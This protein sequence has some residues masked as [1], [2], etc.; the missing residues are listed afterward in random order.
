[1]GAFTDTIIAVYLVYKLRTIN[2]LQFSY[3]TKWYVLI[4]HPITRTYPH[5][6]AVLS[7]KLSHILSHVVSLRRSLPQPP[8]SW[9][10]P[11]SD[12]SA[13]IL[14]FASTSHILCPYFASSPLFI[15]AF[16]LFFDCNGRVYTLTILLNFIT[17]HEWRK[18]YDEK[19]RSTRNDNGKDNSDFQWKG[20]TW[21]RR[22]RSSMWPSEPFTR[23]P[24]ITMNNAHYPKP[25]I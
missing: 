25:R 2:V 21:S 1:M 14:T 22:F 7:A 18:D 11:L 10:F 4:L 8:Q 16:L 9:L 17:F 3:P 5:T 23:F 15:I 19:R 12:V 13:H 6:H 24:S 20:S